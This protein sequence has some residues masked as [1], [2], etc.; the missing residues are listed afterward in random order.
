MCQKLPYLSAM[1]CTACQKG[2]SVKA[3]SKP[4]GHRTNT[5]L[6][7]VHSDL[8]GPMESK[9][10]RYICTLIGDHSRMTMLRAIPNK[11][12]A[13]LEMINVMETQTFYQKRKGTQ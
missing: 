11:A 2:K 3:V 10:Q 6:E 1:L 7:T 4:T 12:D 9:G 13:V 8:C 5:L